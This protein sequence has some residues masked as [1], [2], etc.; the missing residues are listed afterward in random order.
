MV[1]DS[2][3]C[4]ADDYFIGATTKL[5]PA[6]AVAALLILE[7]GRYVMQL[8]DLLPGIFYPGHWGCFGGAVDED[9]SAIGG[10]TRELQEELGYT[11]YDCSEFMRFDF[12]FS[13]LGHGKIFRIYYEVYVPLTAFKRFVLHEGVAFEAFEGRDL[14]VNHR[15][16]PY[17]AFAVWTH[18][19]KS[20]FN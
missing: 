5:A 16:T 19:N 3:W 6:N 11:L 18:M 4:S 17:D 12:D 7:D 1:K 8:R 13:N 9:E 2:V 10:L 20:R 15:V 14:L